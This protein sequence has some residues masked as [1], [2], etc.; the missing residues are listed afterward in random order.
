MERHPSSFSSYYVYPRYL[1][2]VS[3]FGISLGFWLEFLATVLS[4]TLKHVTHDCRL[5]VFNPPIFILTEHGIFVFTRVYTR[6]IMLHAKMY[7]ASHPGFVLHSLSLHSIETRN[8]IFTQTPSIAT[9]FSSLIS[10]LYELQDTHQVNTL[11]STRGWGR[12]TITHRESPHSS[13]SRVRR[14]QVT[15]LSAQYIL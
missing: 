3:S 6:F 5:K 1:F 15:A 11:S 7:A 12:P 8:L 13:S 9:F 2:V 14:T 10:P 4:A